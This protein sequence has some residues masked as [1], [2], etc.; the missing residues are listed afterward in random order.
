MKIIDK[1]VSVLTSIVSTLSYVGFLAIMALI[2]V[3]VFLRKFFR[4][5]VTGTYELVQYLL[6]CGVFASFAYTQSLRGHVH[7]TMFIAKFPK[8]LRFIVYGLTGVFSTVA[9]VV[10]TYAAAIQTNYSMTAGTKTGVLGVPL[11]PFFAVECFCMGVFAVT[12]A[13]DVVKS[14]IALGNQEV[15]DDIQSSW[16]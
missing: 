3:D 9:A 4:G 15:A 14:F 13:W 8:H 5:G 1:V 11:Y 6:M 2:A 16:S 12:L 7:V 10:L